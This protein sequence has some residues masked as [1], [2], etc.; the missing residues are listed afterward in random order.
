M[1]FGKKKTKKKL[2]DAIHSNKL[3]FIMYYITLF[4]F[5]L[6]F[7]PAGGNIHIHHKEEKCYDEEIFFYHLGCHQWVSIGE[8]WSLREFLLVFILVFDE[9]YIYNI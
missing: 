4:F 3:E 8:R 7:P 9:A 1:R 2:A 5:S 6:F